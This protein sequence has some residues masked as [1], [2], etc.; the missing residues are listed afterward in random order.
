[1]MAKSWTTAAVL[2]I[3]LQKGSPTN[4]VVS[5]SD[6]T[7]IA[8]EA[9]GMAMG[10]IRSIDTVTLP[11]TVDEDNH[12]DLWAVVTAIGRRLVAA[13][14]GAMVF[15]TPPMLIRMED[16]TAMIRGWVNA[17]LSDSDIMGHV[18]HDLDDFE[19]V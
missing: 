11:D 2:K 13:R 14:F 9:S 10:I 8:K 15:R 7:A 4:P 17:Q 5:D 12:Q 19:W 18:T 3:G 6:L 1:M 16:A